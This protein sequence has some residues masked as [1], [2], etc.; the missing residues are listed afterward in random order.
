MADETSKPAAARDTAKIVRITLDDLPAGTDRDLPACTSR[1]TRMPLPDG[2]SHGMLYRDIVRIAWPTFFEQILTQL[3]NMADQMMVGRLPGEIGV[4]A[5]SAVGLSMQPKFVLMAMVMAINVGATAMV[6]RY[7]GQ[8]D[9]ERVSDVFRHALLLGL[10]VSSLLA[11]S[12]AMWAAP[13]VRFIGGDGI[14][15]AACAYAEEYLRIQMYGFVP[16]CLTFTVTAA[17]R[18]IGESRVPLIYNT[19]ANV[20]NIV[21]N[22]L[23]IY[24]KCGF[25]EMRVAGASLATV[26]G[27]TCA[28]VF[29]AVFVLNRKRY[30]F[31]DLRRRFVFDAGILKNVV[32]IGLP[33]MVEQL[34]MR[35]GV[36]VYT[37]TVTGLGDLYYATHQICMNIQAMSF[38]TG[39]AFAASST[40]LM[41]Q[42]L[43]KRRLDMAENYTRH[44]NT[45]GFLVS[46]ALGAALAIFG[47][48]VVWLYNHTEE[49]VTLGGAIL[50]MVACIQPFQSAQFIIA[51]ALR[52]AG[53]T[54]F[55]AVV[56]FI[57]VILVRSG[58]AML[59]INVLGLGLWGAWYALVADQVLRTLLLAAHY[60]RGAWRFI[61]LQ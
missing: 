19:M 2:V 59:M 34:F 23:L 49:I 35:A 1:L 24:G 43:G 48:D 41:G 57:T 14:S 12:G 7:R 5:L 53:D 51:G 16:L 22:Y 55:P 56:M 39:Q 30:I 45:V 36:I 6:A 15:A 46:L 28:F 50:V 31:L 9:R 58:L 61:K 3:T 10:A 27:Q 47:R 32:R 25:P 40:T 37:R 26:I 52:G 33:S 42:S 44:T 38:M 21:F 54:R 17:L 29:A 13:L 8:H 11:L 18:G 4:Q 20:I 60:R